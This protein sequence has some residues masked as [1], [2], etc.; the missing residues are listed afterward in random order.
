MYGNSFPSALRHHNG[1][2]KEDV[3]FHSIFSVLLRS[4]TEARLYALAINLPDVTMHVQNK[5]T[6]LFIITHMTLFIIFEIPIDVQ[7]IDTIHCESLTISI[8]QL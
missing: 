6:C 5:R 3:C 2:Y 8:W 1:V 4:V 7:Y